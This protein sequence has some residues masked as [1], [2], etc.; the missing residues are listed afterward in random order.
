[1]GARRSLIGV[2]GTRSGWVAA[3]LA[4]ARLRHLGRLAELVP[5]SGDVIAIDI[6]LAY[7]ADGHPRACEIAA[8]EILRTC[9]GGRASSIFLTHPAEIYGSA[10]DPEDYRTRYGRALQD[11]RASAFGGISRQSFALGNKIAEAIAYAEEARKLGAEVIEVHPETEFALLE[12][13]A[14]QTTPMRGKRT[15]TGLRQR[16][17][18]LTAESADYD[19]DRFHG[20][21]QDAAPDD[22]IDAVAAARVARHYASGSASPLGNRDRGGLIWTAAAVLPGQGNVRPEPTR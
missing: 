3:D 9:G 4:P 13:R 6:P 1:M 12:Q 19:P 17:A 11:S 18:A 14:V 10:D 5:A 8:R 21:P 2:D 7:P 16:W 15:W 22:V 20:D